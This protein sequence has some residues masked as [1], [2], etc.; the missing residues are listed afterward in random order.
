MGTRG[1]ALSTLLC[2]FAISKEMGSNSA[3][4]AE[5]RPDRKR[6]INH[7]TSVG[8]KNGYKGGEISHKNFPP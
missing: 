4:P 8:N 1:G 5:A 7:I 6:R 2:E 3:V